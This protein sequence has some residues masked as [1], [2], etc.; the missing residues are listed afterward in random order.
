MDIPQRLGIL[1]YMTAYVALA[2][3]LECPH[4]A[5]PINSKVTVSDRQP[6]SLATYTCDAGYKIFGSSVLSCGSD[7]VW[8][9][10]LPVCATNVAW[11]KPVN[12][13]ST[14]RG[15]KGENA[16]DGL[17]TSIHDGQH[18]TETLVESSPWWSVD[19]LQ[20]YEVTLVKITTRG[21]CG[22]QPVQDIEIRVGDYTNIQKNRLCAWFPGTI[23]EGATKELT[24]A[25]SMKGRYVFI[26]MV[27][28]EGSMSLCEVEVYSTQEFSKERC[29]DKAQVT[30]LSI[31]NRTC[32][33][34][35]VTEGGDFERGRQYCQK[36]GGDLVHG[37]G[38]A[39]HSFLKSELERLKDTMR[40]NLIWIGAQRE[41][42]YISRTWRWVDDKV[43]ERPRWGQEQPNNYNG[44]QNCVVLDGGREWA[45][46]DVG[47]ELNYLHWICQF[48]PTSCGSPDSN[49]NTTMSSTDDTATGASVTY[50]CPEG[51]V[52]MGN[53]TRTCLSTGFW[54]GDAPK[55]KYVDCGNPDDID[56]GL[57]VLVDGRTTYGAK[58]RFECNKNYT[59][60][61]ENSAICS[62]DGT[63]SPQP[64]ECLYSWCP[65]VTE[66]V[67]GK[68]DMSG[69]QAGDTATFSCDSGYSIQGLKTVSCTLGGV[70]SGATP[71]CKFIDCGVP[72][73]LRDGRMTLVNGTTYLGS[74]ARYE[75]GPDF[76][77]H[78]PEERICLED[79]HWSDVAP[80]CDLVSCEEPQVPDGGYVTG[81][82]FDVHEE[83][84]YHCESGHYLTG[85][86]IRVCT[87]SGDWSG[88]IPTCTY[89]DCGRV[90]TLPRGDVVYLNES[91]FL[92]SHLQYMCNTNYRLVGE[93]RR[94]CSKD[95]LWSGDLP[96][97]EEIRCPEPEF[98]D[99]AKTSVAGNDRRMSTTIVRRREHV[100]LDNTYR[101]GSVV[102]YR[103]ERGYVVDGASM[104]T[105][106]SDGTWSHQA[107]T[108]KFVDCGLPES[109]SPGIYRL[110]SNSTSYGSQVAYECSE[111]WKLEG[112]I[113]RFCQ[114]NGTWVGESP[115]CVEVF[116]PELQSLL[117][118]ALSVNEGDRR[119]GTTATYTCDKGRL[120]VGEPSRQCRTHGIW[121][122]TQPRCEWVSCNM[123]EEIE[124]GRIVRLNESLIYGSVVEYHCLPKYVLDGPFTRSC[125]D[126]GLW[127]GVAPRCSLDTKDYGIFEDN[128]VDGTSNSARGGPPGSLEEASN[129]GLYVGL[130]VGLIAVVAVALLFAFLKAR[131]QKVKEEEAPTTLKPR[132]THHMDSMSYADLSDPTTGNNIYENIPD[133]VEEYTDMSS[134]NYNT[135]PSH[136]YSNGRQPVYTNDT[137]QPMYT[138]DNNQPMYTN[139][140]MESASPYGMTASLNRPPAHIMRRPRMPPPQPPK[141]PTLTE[142]SAVVTINGITV[143]T[144][145][146]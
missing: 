89:V 26:Q 74:A 79:S 112:R 8:S 58:V 22:H 18:C 97:C 73:D 107:P 110:L 123:P 126:Q 39:T 87:R 45:W 125:T 86:S 81:Y 127:A 24:C 117:S 105:C 96:K 36:H 6:G 88:D 32:Y 16:N 121:T 92:D 47:C 84:E 145:S 51:N 14:A 70:W 95:G 7:G 46:N 113:R 49:E 132:N 100:T 135:T 106:M 38:Q 11:K 93:N 43:V 1:V 2:Q 55:C 72:E 57:H 48:Q 64:P 66:P 109:I 111:N 41:P 143:S 44:K 10:D 119:V 4:P 76:W 80:V 25:R 28:V 60:N 63:W 91:T 85:D 83:V 33:E 68:V 15:G 82:S 108:C 134:G 30:S 140:M 12:Q 67:N 90:P 94:V 35:Q 131:Q 27:G 21:C 115:L 124:N 69:R 129:T 137:H 104:R 23:E 52:V 37:I 9:G 136:T 139:G 56:N 5:V 19:L 144:N 61:G 116:C 138:N 103:C 142:P 59:I 122:G 98:P 40:T 102:T 17:V 54:S 114:E 78:G 120:L 128:T 101:I 141:V 34:L 99:K 71:T 13:S 133:D 3:G 50:H 31:F 29:T 118:D 130:A 53:L 65:N 62:E 75:C 146:T 20:E 42:Q 77:L